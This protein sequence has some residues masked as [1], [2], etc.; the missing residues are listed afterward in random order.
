MASAVGDCA[1]RI[2]GYCRSWR[3]YISDT[4]GDDPKKTKASAINKE[5]PAPRRRRISNKTK[6]N[7]SNN[8]TRVDGY[9]NLVKI[10]AH[11][12]QSS[13]EVSSQDLV[14]RITT[15]LCAGKEIYPISG[16]PSE[17]IRTE[18]T[19]KLLLI[20]KLRMLDDH[21]VDRYILMV[22]N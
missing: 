14:K 8:N 5:R 4:S 10:F 21:I 15:A 19:A 22:T 12:T 9:I 13:K 1:T 16:Q 2:G 7:N 17:M 20:S 3:W 6:A 18:T 11:V